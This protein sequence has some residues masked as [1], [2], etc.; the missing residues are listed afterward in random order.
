MTLGIFRCDVN[1]S[2]FKV[3]VRACH[4]EGS[5]SIQEAL[6]CFSFKPINISL[7]L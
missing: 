3:T 5:R 7:R 4:P 1:L 2:M 6:G